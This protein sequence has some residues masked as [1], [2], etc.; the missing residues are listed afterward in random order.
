[1]FVMITT[2]WFLS[3]L[4]ATSIDLRMI[5][6]DYGCINLGDLIFSAVLLLLGPIGLLAVMGELCRW[7]S[8]NSKRL[9][10]CIWEKK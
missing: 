3:G 1:M 5:W 6:K 9:N 7:L 8:V 2:L 4:I 10:K